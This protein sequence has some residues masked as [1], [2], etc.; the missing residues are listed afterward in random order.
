MGDDIHLNTMTM[1]RHAAR[2]CTERPMVYRTPNVLPSSL[3][4]LC[5]GMAAGGS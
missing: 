3:I 5:S 4:I 2:T 1:V